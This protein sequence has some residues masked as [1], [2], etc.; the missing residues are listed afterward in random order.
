[1]R[2]VEF[3]CGK[4]SK[5]VKNANNLAI[6]KGSFMR[7]SFFRGLMIPHRYPLILSSHF[8]TEYTFIRHIPCVGVV[9]PKPGWRCAK[10]PFRR[11]SDC[12]VSAKT[13]LLPAAAITGTGDNDTS[14]QSQPPNGDHAMR[15]AD[16][17][18]AGC[19]TPMELTAIS[20]LMISSKRGSRKNSLT[21]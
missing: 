12:S 19:E 15:A 11:T 9:S 14:A 13:G 2:S 8:T 4:F 6:F 1:M 7:G 20:R 18:P 21:N 10:T 17:D 5:R 16:R 3:R